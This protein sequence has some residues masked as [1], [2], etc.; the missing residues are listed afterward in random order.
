M[1]GLVR[2]L[3]LSSSAVGKG[4][5]I[6][7]KTIGYRRL[8]RTGTTGAALEKENA[9]FGRARSSLRRR[10]GTRASGNESVG[11]SVKEIKRIKRFQKHATI[12][13]TRT[14]T[15][16]VNSRAHRCPLEDFGRCAPSPLFKRDRQIEQLLR[17]LS[18][19]HQ[20]PFFLAYALLCGERRQPSSVRSRRAGSRC[21][22]PYHESGALP[23]SSPRARTI[24]DPIACV[25]SGESL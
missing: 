24:G 10:W 18:A 21:R 7:G 15:T 4:V 8:P 6:S 17:Q 9:R 22:R 14:A 1:G 12:F 20:L 2:F 5:V 23:F 11:T 25:L 3:L 13:P 19:R 16:R